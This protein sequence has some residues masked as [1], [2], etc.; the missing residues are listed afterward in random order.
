[1]TSLCCDGDGTV[2]VSAVS[3]A[4]AG[5]A[6]VPARPLPR[7]VSVGV[8]SCKDSRIKLLLGQLE[9]DIEVNG[10]QLS[11]CRKLPHLCCLP[12]RSKSAFCLPF[13][14]RLALSC[15]NP[16]LVLRRFPGEANVCSAAR[17]ELQR[18]CWHQ[19]DTAS[20]GWVAGIY[21]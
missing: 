14:H 7:L 19:G 12:N 21:H 9:Q 20:T 11:K 6:G 10:A 1:M 17:N 4:L 15:Q 5:Q 16:S 3:L 18:F 8:K 13:T 2:A